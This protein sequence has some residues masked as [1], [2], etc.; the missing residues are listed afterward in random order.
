[1]N[2]IDR[3]IYIL[4][5]KFKYPI[6]MT[7][8]TDAIPICFHLKD[9]EL[10]E[11]AEAS[12]IVKKPS[13]RENHDYAVCAD[14]V[15]VINTTSQMTAEIG[16]AEIQIQIKDDNKNLFTFI[17]PMLIEKSMTAIDSETGSVIID[18]YLEKIHESTEKANTA[19]EGA[20]AAKEAADEA[21]GGANAAK[22]AADEAAEGA[23]AAK[24]AAEEA[25]EGANT[26]KEAADDAAE[27]ANEIA[28]EINTKLENGEFTGSIE[29]GRV[30]TGQPGTEAKVENV[31]TK[32][33]AVLNIT[34]PRGDT[35]NI[36]NI[37]EVTMEFEE[38]STRQNINSGD[39]FHILF[40]K[41]KK[42]FTDL[43]NGAASTLLGANLTKDRVLISNASGK[44]SVSSI[45]S[46]ILGYLSGLTSNV[47]TQL[48]AKIN[49]NKIVT[50]TSITSS[51]Y[52][53][54]GKTVSDALAALSNKKKTKLA[55][56]AF[57]EESGRH[58]SLLLY[59]AIYKSSGSM[60]FTIPAKNIPDESA[61]G[62]LLCNVGGIYYP[63]LLTVNTNGSLTFRSYPIGASEGTNPA[64]A[65]LYGSISWIA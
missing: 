18:E 8:G 2:R 47:Q 31:G 65:Y 49:T 19:A 61:A 30:E 45:T 43:S 3:E 1:M 20:N 40:G 22:E 27:R 60:G 57:L 42:W 34:I 17:Y 37:G 7:Q 62:Y 64:S 33:D 55:N 56:G 54:D 44:V 14:G 23:N 5:N 16:K 46:T 13:G 12:I 25:A 51:G 6:E 11:N 52:L 53:M 15:I 28:L 4:E 24:E 58:C 41:I 50:S 48:N 26:A 35:G 10:G 39:T 59:N 32:K 38:V 63:G 21:A 29:I 9:Y 36:E